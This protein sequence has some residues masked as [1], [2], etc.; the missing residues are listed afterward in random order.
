MLLQV[1][2]LYLYAARIPEFRGELARLSRAC[3]DACVFGRRTRANSFDGGYAAGGTRVITRDAER[4]RDRDRAHSPTSNGTS[5]GGGGGIGSGRCHYTR[6]S[7]GALS[8]TVLLPASASSATIASN[9]RLFARDS[10]N[11]T[12]RTFTNA[13]YPF[14]DVRGT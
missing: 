6:N 8:V 11:I 14:S 3:V 2:T 5:T 12:V 7:N 9:S 13:C 10:H 1:A 4:D